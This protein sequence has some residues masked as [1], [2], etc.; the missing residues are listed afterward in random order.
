MA[1]LR[2]RWRTL[3]WV[4]LILA[5]LIAASCGLSMRW[6][7]GYVRWD[8][9][10]FNAAAWAGHPP[11]FFAGINNLSIRVCRYYAWSRGRP[12]WSVSRAHGSPI[13]L[14]SV[15]R[16]SSTR[17]SYVD[18]FIPLWI[19]FLIV[20]LPTGLLWWHDR[21]IHPDQ[22]Q[23]CGYNLTGNVSGVCPECG[24]K[25]GEEAAAKG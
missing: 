3:K 17:G 16:F 1:R 5:L 21:R 24:E 12:E 25:V 7:L 20:A 11:A 9:R 2:R 19:P 22:C 10:A 23:R 14:P 15:D 8:K 13:W 18:I 6:C 4:G